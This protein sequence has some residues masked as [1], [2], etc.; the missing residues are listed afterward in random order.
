[1]HHSQTRRVGDETLNTKTSVFN[2]ILLPSAF[3]LE[4]NEF[5]DTK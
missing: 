5:H 4:K 3:E 1:M 2:M